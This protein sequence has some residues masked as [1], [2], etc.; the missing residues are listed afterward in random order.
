MG[1][2]WT[3]CPFC[4]IFRPKTMTIMPDSIP[5]I[6]YRFCLGPFLRRPLL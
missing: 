4:A 1:K 6:R 2:K 3:N 5:T